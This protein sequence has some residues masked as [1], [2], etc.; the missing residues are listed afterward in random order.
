LAAIRCSRRS[1]I[2]FTGTAEPQ[3][4][5]AN[6]NVFR[7]NLAAHAEAAADMTFMQV[8][9][10]RLAA[11]HARQAVAVPMRHLGGAVQFEDA[12]RT[13]AMAPRVSIGTPLWRPI[14]RSSAT[15]VCVGGE[16]RSPRRHSLCA[17]WPLRSNAPA[18]NAA[19]G[20]SALMIS[21]SSSI[22]TATRSAASS[23]L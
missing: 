1:S 21:G 8:H 3:R 15:T 16:S 6:E 18:S 5:E 13:R 23:A 22:S 19:G 10:R 11:E 9:F 12:A 14:S 20:A 2:H 4:G 7:I 17:R